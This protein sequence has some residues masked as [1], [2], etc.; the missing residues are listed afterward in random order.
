MAR[1]PR[2]PAR[3]A[4]PPRR[5]A[6]L[7]SASA[8][9]DR[10]SAEKVAIG[11][12]AVPQPVQREV[13]AR[14]GG[15]CSRPGCMTVL[16]RDLLRSK[17]SH[18]GEIAHNVSALPGG[19]RGDPKR[20]KDLS[21]DPDNLIL[22]C[23]THHKLVDKPGAA[24]DYPEEMLREWKVL[25]ETAIR[26]A[27]GL[28]SGT[29]AH[30]LVFQAPIGKQIVAIDPRT[31]PFAML[32]RQ[33]VL[34]RNE[35]VARLEL[36]I[37]PAKT[38]AYWTDLIGRVRAKVAH[39]QSAFGETNKP[40]ALFALA[41]IPALMALGFA[42]GHAAQVSTFQFD[43]VPN[44]GAGDWRFPKPD[45]PA[46]AYRVNVPETLQPP[47]ALVF[48]LSGVIERSRVENALRA[49]TRGDPQPGTIIEI[50][51]DDPSL[52]FVRG[53]ADI[54]EF[55]RALRK[56]W[57]RLERHLPKSTPIHVFP[58]IPASL[59]VTFGRFVKPKVSFPFR[60]YDAEGPN[61]PFSFAVELPFV[62]SAPGDVK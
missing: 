55:A 27:G 39:V 43:P 13:W 26:N 52:D 21:K 46:R 58:A 41:D 22:L 37:Y 16:Y 56:C 42:L 12:D 24:A 5:A 36:S 2:K 57:G 11:R 23:P 54:D 61:A 4:T 6:S 35:S 60:I 1:G 3:A 48:S 25:H 53:P 40:L 8:R 59:A 38:P 28:C 30:A 10:V 15:I 18:F 20:S 33:L 62:D 45:A 32:Q 7:A 29:L 31:I 34:E 14:A 47:I 50:T 9:S 17:S 51:V 44:G 49:A 19:E